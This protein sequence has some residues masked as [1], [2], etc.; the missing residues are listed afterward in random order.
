MSGRKPLRTRINPKFFRHEFDKASVEE[1]L[2]MI[3][4]LAEVN[5]QERQQKISGIMRVLERDLHDAT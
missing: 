1:A 3:G 5:E 2:W 4:E